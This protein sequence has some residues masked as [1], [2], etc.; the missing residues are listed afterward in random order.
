MSRASEDELS[1]RPRSARATTVNKVIWS[2]RSER[3]ESLPAGVLSIHRETYEVL[4]LVTETSNTGAL[5]PAGPGSKGDT[6]VA[7]I[8]Q[9][10]LH[11]KSP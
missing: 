2:P 3:R 9:N 5:A 6:N 8:D 1:P 7:D 4:L 10:T 11:R